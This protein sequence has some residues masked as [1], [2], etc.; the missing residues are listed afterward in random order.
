MTPV[1][2]G[3]VLAG[4]YRVEKVLGQGGMGVV[5]AATHLQLGQ[6]V[7]LKF[8]LPEM[9][10]SGEGVERFL[11]EAR[12]AVQIRGEH[13]ARITDVGTLETGAPYMVME[14]LDGTDLAALLRDSG[15][16]PIAL[17]VDYVLQC[18][19][20]IAESHSLGIVHRDLKPANLFLTQSPDGSALIKVLDFGI[21]KV[22]GARMDGKD[23]GRLTATA[24]I[25]GSPLYMSPEQ[26][27]S[28]RDV[29]FRT[30]IWSLGI[31]LHEL[32]AAQP[33]Y[34][35][36]TAPALMVSIAVNPPAPLRSHRPDA[37]A[38][39]EAVV[40]RCLEK[41]RSRRFANVGELALSLAP[42]A[43]SGG[44]AAAERARRMLGMSSGAGSSQR[45][46]PSASQAPA[47]VVGTG[48]TFHAT[49]TAAAWGGT[50][51]EFRRSQRGKWLGLG[52]ALV[53]L[54]A[55]GIFGLRALSSGETAAL[56]A[57]IPS[58]GTTNAA[59]RASALP[60]VQD[61]P[62]VVPAPTPRLEPALPSPEPLR[63]SQPGA[64]A[65]VRPTTA[66]PAPNSGAV[67]AAKPKAKAVAVPGKELFDDP[68]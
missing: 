68:D 46:L 47:G 43:G 41:D 11:R 32:I 39:L 17:A 66:K 10:D 51:S 67:G 37:P 15:P 53:L 4:K 38:G 28:S 56:D 29:D 40:N 60:V 36:D 22:L 2:A 14:Y 57:P 6:L 3:A 13:V 54:T 1:Q 25:V 20:A 7:A 23:A 42:F 19:E 35:A 63:A 55:A 45:T 62:L 21:S 16:L 33:P 59:A 18:C 30:D 48:G 44:H 12:A 24:A 49:A 26:I 50:G 58:A 61:A 8:L 5:V 34:M 9:L 31:I 52:V 64:P 27:T 65:L